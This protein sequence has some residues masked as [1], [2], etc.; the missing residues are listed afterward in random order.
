[1]SV[2][3]SIKTPIFVLSQIYEKNEP[4]GSLTTYELIFVQQ[5]WNPGHHMCVAAKDDGYLYFTRCDEAELN[6]KWEW[7]EINDDVLARVNNN[8]DAPGDAPPELD[9]I[10]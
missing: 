8:L 10:Q 9:Y 5:F 1:M 2:E 3:F 7:E 6:Q 4:R